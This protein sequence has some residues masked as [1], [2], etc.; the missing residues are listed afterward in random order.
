MFNNVVLT[1]RLTK[2]PEL[3]Y[4]PNGVAMVSFTLAVQR[5]FQNNNGER[6]SDFIMCKAFKKTAE[7]IANHFTKGSL[8]G[9][10]GRIQT[11]SYEGQDGKRVY[12]TDVMVNQIHFLEK[13]QEVGQQNQGHYS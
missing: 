10:E 7:L 5:S 4:S 9:V 3:K 13:K 2:D 11:G 6:E 12:T 1:G 8:L